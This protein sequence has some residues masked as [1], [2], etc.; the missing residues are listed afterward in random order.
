MNVVVL[1]LGWVASLLLAGDPSDV[2]KRV[3]PSPPLPLAPIRV[4]QSQASSSVQQTL[5]HQNP[6]SPL[7]LPS[8]LPP[9]APALTLTPLFGFG[10]RIL[11]DRH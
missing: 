1:H 6:V 2:K 5:H 10:A 8:A 3:P 4:N 9:P 11:F 7:A